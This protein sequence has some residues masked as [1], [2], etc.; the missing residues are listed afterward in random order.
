M[1]VT[2]ES[3]MIRSFKGKTPQIHPTAFV[4]ETAYIVGEVVIGE[5]ASIW[6]GAVIRGDF[7]SISIGKNTAIE[8]NCIVH[9]WDC[10]IGDNVLVGHGAVIHCKSVGDGCM[11]GI[12]AVLLQGAEIGEK[13]FIAAG[14]LITPNTKIPPRSLVMGSPAKVKEELTQDKL[15][16]MIMG[17]DAYVQLGQQYKQQGL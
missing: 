2:E 6:P 9:S 12:N 7:G 14:A 16:M 1:D 17:N 13:C 5:N 10:I 3:I 15:S 11:V 4:S 8:D